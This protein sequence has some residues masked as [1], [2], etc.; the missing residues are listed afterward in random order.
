MTLNRKNQQHNDLLPMMIMYIIYIQNE[1][2]NII[3]SASFS[4]PPYIFQKCLHR[5]SGKS[6][7]YTQPEPLLKLVCDVAE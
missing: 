3:I 6:A 5:V 7:I 4:H 2:D 1:S